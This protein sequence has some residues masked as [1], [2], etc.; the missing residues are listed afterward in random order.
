[1]ATAEETAEAERVLVRVVGITAV[2][3]RATTKA[4]ARAVWQAEVGGREEWGR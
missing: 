2:V 3:S 1:M 4:V